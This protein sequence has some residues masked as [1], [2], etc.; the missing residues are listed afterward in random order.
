MAIKTKISIP[1]K[2]KAIT[3]DVFDTFLFRNTKSE[4]ERFKEVSRIHKNILKEKGYS[5]STNEIFFLRQLCHKIAYES[6]SLEKTGGDRK[7]EEIFNLMLDSLKI[8]NK[9]ILNA[10]IKSELIYEKDNLKVNKKLIKCIEK[11]RKNNLQ[12]YFISDMYLSKGN[13]QYLID[14]LAKNFRYKGIYVSSEFN[15]TK[16]SGKLFDTFLKN[17]N[18]KPEEIIH[19]GDNNYSDYLLPKS[20]NISVIYLPR[21]RIIKIIRTVR[22]FL[23]YITNRRIILND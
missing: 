5:F 19:I 16:M 11:L 22:N 9:E 8:K 3:L 6:K 7:L 17:E 13:I 21:N 15:Q 20:K 18:L 10:F 12:I 14:K 4:K 23:F 1:D 2:I